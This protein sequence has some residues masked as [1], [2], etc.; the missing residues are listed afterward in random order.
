MRIHVLP[1]TLLALLAL[2]ATGHAQDAA[3][4][5]EPKPATGS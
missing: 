4:K 3:P 2:A 5:P 1:S